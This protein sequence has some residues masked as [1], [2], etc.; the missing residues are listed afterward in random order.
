MDSMTPE[1]SRACTSGMA[2]ALRAVDGSFGGSDRF[3]AF[4]KRDC[5]EVFF[6]FAHLILPFSARLAFRGAAGFSRTKF[7]MPSVPCPSML[8]F[9]SS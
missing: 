9:K 5:R 3:E 8:R 6:F 4:C 1:G 2:V 7:S